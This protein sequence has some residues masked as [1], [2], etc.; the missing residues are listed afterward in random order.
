M[1]SSLQGISIDVVSALQ[2]ELVF[3][4]LVKRLMMKKYA[5]HLNCPAVPFSFCSNFNNPNH[6]P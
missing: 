4:Y 1:P 3:S 6:L 5:Y 2:G